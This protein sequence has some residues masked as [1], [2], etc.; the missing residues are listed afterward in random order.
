[1]SCTDL[2][3]LRFDKKEAWV[4]PG[5]VTSSCVSIRAF[6]STVFY[7]KSVSTAD[8]RDARGGSAAIDHM[9]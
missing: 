1:M 8:A 2:A 3:E 6:T 4:Y 9:S 7:H 5:G